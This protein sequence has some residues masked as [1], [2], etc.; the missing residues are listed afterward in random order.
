VS[1]P[2]LL[3]YRPGLH[4][5]A[6][7]VACATAVLIFIGGLVT[8]TGSALAVPDWPL[9][10]GQVFPRMTGGVLFEHGHR[11][12]GATI[13]LLTIVLA[14]WLWRSEPRR[15]VR[16][17]GL[18]TLTAVSLQGVLGGLT[19]LRRLPLALAV[20][21]AGL[22]QIVLCLTVTI[23]L[24]TSAGWMEAPPRAPDAGAP[25]LRALTRVAV[26]VVYLQILVGA[27]V[28]HSGAG[29]AVPDFPL[30]FGRLWPAA[31]LMSTPVAYQL[32]HR[33]GALLVALCLI[34]TVAAAMRRHGSVP[35]LRRPALL[36][37]LLLAWQV[38]LG[39]AI[40]WTKR[41]VVPTT[42]H[43]LS[44]AL[45]LATALVLALRATR[46]LAPLPSDRSSSPAS[47][48]A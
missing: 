2:D 28:R 27:V 39:A 21:H 13:G 46:L 3:A 47:T 6:V 17:L 30:A 37:A 35:G 38:Y 34:W 24:V 18:I 25:S 11:M 16:W 43:V 1:G 14:V 12:A 45:V 5:Y 20:S 23:A 29:L 26:A 33:A 42:A 19:V 41:A 4:R 15:W 10:Y 48:A 36:L 44:G 40:I 22:A 7:G 31:G 32:L 8:S 9:S